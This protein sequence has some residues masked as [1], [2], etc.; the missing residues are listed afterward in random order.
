MPVSE[1]HIKELARHIERVWKPQQLLDKRLIDHVYGEAL[2]E[3]PDTA[4]KERN[5]RIEPERMHTGEAA[6]VVAL[7]KPRYAL[8]AVPGAQYTGSGQRGEAVSDKIE[9][10]LAESM[11]RLNPATDSPRDDGVEQ[12][13][14][15]GRK[16]ELLVPGGAGRTA[17]YWHDFPFKREG[18]T[19]DAWQRRFEEWERKAP[20]PILLL[21]LPAESTFPPSIGSLDEEVLCMI[22]MTWAEL[23]RVFSP[24][25]LGNAHPGEAKR[26][27]TGSLAIYS[28]RKELAYAVAKAEGG[29][30]LGGWHIGGRTEFHMLRTLEHK[31]GRTA[32][33]ILPGMTTA[34]KEPGY[35]WRSVLF[36]VRDMLDEIERVANWTATGRK[37]GSLPAFKAWIHGDNLEGDGSDAKTLPMADG[38]VVMLDPGDPASG[39]PR[40]DMEPLH[41]PRFGERDIDML[42]FLLG[43]SELITGTSEILHGASQLSGEPAWSVNFKAEMAKAQLRDLTRAVGAADLDFYE[44]VLRAVVAWDEPLRLTKF[45]G[46][47]RT[48]IVLKPEEVKDFEPVLK[49]ELTPQLPINDRADW[50]LGMSILERKRAI[51]LPFPS[52]KTVAERFFGIEQLFE[53]FKEGM[54]WEFITS[55]GVQSFLLDQARK[56]A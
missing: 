49:T 26:Y 4:N 10:G 12:L 35:Y 5:R 16:A 3:A 11:E 18:E 56:E 19:E 51:G 39:R 53:E 34:R 52:A 15:L 42:T 37:F 1:G 25:E 31:M 21:N 20:L 41:V 7:V 30:N 43:R 46:A 32:I 33:R 38:D 2:T 54:T 47:K 23:E 55:E 28:D 48:E 13:V 45:E 50:D 27:E 14:V 24:Q 22:D 40:E 36:Y 8:P 29:V 44:G 17:G 9:Q 6:R